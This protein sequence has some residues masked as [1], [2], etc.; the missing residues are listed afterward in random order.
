MPA[1]VSSILDYAHMIPYDT[2]MAALDILDPRTVNQTAS[3]IVGSR[4]RRDQTTHY[5]SDSYNLAV[6]SLDLLLSASQSPSQ[7]CPDTSTLAR[8]AWHPNP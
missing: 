4:S 2:P 7:L 6:A 8:T 5:A 1:A 3:L